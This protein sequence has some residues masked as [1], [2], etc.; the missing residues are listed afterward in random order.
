MSID[1]LAAVGAVSGPVTVSQVFGELTW[2][3]SQSPRHAAFHVADL[4]WLLMPPIAARQFHLF[5]DGNRPVGAALWAAP[6]PAAE[7][8][9]AKQPLSPQN[10]L[11]VDEWTGGERLWL[12]EL[13]A[14]SATAENRQIEVMLGDLMTGP[15]KGREFRML[16]LDPETGDGSAAVIGADAGNELVSRIA[17]VIRRGQAR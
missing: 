15:F 12:A 14:P 7:E 5:R 13:L 11:E 8:R 10:R 6:P 2:L 1:G 16:R 17:K 4:T 3:V 9:I